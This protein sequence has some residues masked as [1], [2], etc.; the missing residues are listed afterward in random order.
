LGNAGD[1]SGD[2]QDKLMAFCRAGALSFNLVSPESADDR[3][4]FAQLM[5]DDEFSKSMS[6]YRPTFHLF[7]TR[8]ATTLLA[9]HA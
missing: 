5:L 6:L 9:T 1:K 8:G 3:P 7:R 2:E 4:V